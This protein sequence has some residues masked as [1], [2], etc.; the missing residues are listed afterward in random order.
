[1]PGLRSLSRWLRA[2]TEIATSFWAL[3]FSSGAMAIGLQLVLPDGQL[4]DLVVQDADHP[5]LLDGH[6]DLELHLLDHA[7]AQGGDLRPFHPVDPGQ[8][9]EHQDLGRRHCLGPGRTRRS[10]PLPPRSRASSKPAANAAIGFEKNMIERASSPPGCCQAVLGLNEYSRES[11]RSGQIIAATRST[12]CKNGQRNSDRFVEDLDRL[13]EQIVGQV[14]LPAVD[15]R[16]DLGP[17]P[18]SR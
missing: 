4:G 17:R 6:A 2:T 15:P 11:S 5:V 3:A 18:R 16:A 9:F 12:H 13:A 14:G 1:M 7:L 10:G 8:L